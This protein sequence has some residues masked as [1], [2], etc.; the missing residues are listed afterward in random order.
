MTRGYPSTGATSAIAPGSTGSTGSAGTRWWAA[1]SPRRWPRS[2][3][4]D[5]V[6]YQLRNV[7]N[8]VR[9]LE[10][11]PR[12]RAQWA[13]RRAHRFGSIDYRRPGRPSLDSQRIA[14]R[15]AC[16]AVLFVARRP[17]RGRRPRV[18]HLG[19]VGPVRTAMGGRSRDDPGE[20]VSNRGSG[21][22]ATS[23][24]ELAAARSR[25]ARVLHGPSAAPQSASASGVAP[26]VPAD[27]ATLRKQVISRVRGRRGDPGPRRPRSRPA[28][29]GLF[30]LRGS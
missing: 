20:N 10:Q 9:L 19:S 1:T 27:A 5:D 4:P 8:V 17:R 24:F 2:S 15:T 30:R 23:S 28:R 25:A 7:Q 22:G 12:E 16:S 18:R 26:A 13:G 11:S 14:F 21:W 3:P 29:P 6:R